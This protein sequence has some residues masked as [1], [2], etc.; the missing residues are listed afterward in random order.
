[1]AWV[2]NNKRNARFNPNRRDDRL[3]DAEVTARRQPRPQ[4]PDEDS[5]SEE[6]INT[7]PEFVLSMESDS[8]VDWLQMALMQAAEGKLKAAALYEVMK[9]KTFVPSEA[10]HRSKLKAMLTANFHLFNA[11]HK[12]A[13]EEATNSWGTEGAAR[14]DTRKKR[15]GSSSSSSSSSNQEA[16]E[17]K[18]RKEKKEEKDKKEKKEKGKE[19]G[20]EKDKGKEKGKQKEREKE[21]EKEKEKEKEHKKEKKKEKGESKEDGVLDR[22]RRKKRRSSSSSSSSSNSSSSSSSSNRKDKKKESAKDKKKAS[23]SSASQKKRSNSKG[24]KGKS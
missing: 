7:E 4:K 13:L 2:N 12:K 3:L 21:R 6:L 23:P 9:N 1:M 18:E 17:K 19:K 15:K 20:H 11:K 5:A 16:K 24:R 14:A 10:A 22:D 8:R